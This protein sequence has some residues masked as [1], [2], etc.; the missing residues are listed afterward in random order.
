VVVI[1]KQRES[2]SKA[3]FITEDE[4]EILRANAVERGCQR[5]A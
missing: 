3:R 2:Q 5:R 4:F 1:P